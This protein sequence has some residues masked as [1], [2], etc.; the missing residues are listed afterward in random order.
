LQR[1]ARGDRPEGVSE[2]PEQ[3]P[4]QDSQHDDPYADLKARTAA[5]RFK[6]GQ[7]GNPAGLS[8]K[9]RLRAAFERAFDDK[10]SAEVAQAVAGV[11][12]N[13]MHQHWA[14]AITHTSRILGLVEPE[15][16]QQVVVTT[17]IEVCDRPDGSRPK[18]EVRS[19]STS[20]GSGAAVTSSN[21]D[22][23][24]EVEL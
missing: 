11:A 15:K 13:P 1:D 3:D 16:P 8:A 21:G 5:H 12:A 4:Q 23:A 9:A 20:T 22:D 18:I 14:H 2:A 24:I 6:K 17:E 7:S 19:V 10:A